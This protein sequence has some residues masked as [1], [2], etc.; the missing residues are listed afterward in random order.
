MANKHRIAKAKQRILCHEIRK[1]IGR[2]YDDA[3]ICEKLGISLLQLAPLKRKI[4]HAAKIRFQN[5]DKFSVYSDYCDRSSE[6]VNEL[7]EI[8]LKFRNRGQWTALVA[9]VKQKKEIYDSVIKLGQDFGLIDRKETELRVSGEMAFSTM[10]DRD[11]KEE[12]EKEVKKMHEIAAGNVIDMRPELLGVTDEEVASYVPNNLV[13][14]DASKDKKQKTKIHS[15][16]K[17]T[18]KK[19]V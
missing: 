19:R 11:V 7:N 3:K 18:L 5:L 8:K 15:K 4:Y 2:N 6:M 13:R 12:I 17:V 10:S 14:L 1:L 9:A 16:I